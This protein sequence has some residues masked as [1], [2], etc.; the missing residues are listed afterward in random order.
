MTESDSKQLRS[1]MQLDEIR[2]R[3]SE[4]GES[5]M[6]P[7]DCLCGIPNC[8]GHPAIDGAIYLPD[9]P[10]GPAF[11]SAEDLKDL[12]HKT[13]AEKKPPEKRG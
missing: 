3:I 5:P 6:Q 1:T 13:P 11:I 10:F 7:G 12:Q 2:R 8:A 4:A 9:H